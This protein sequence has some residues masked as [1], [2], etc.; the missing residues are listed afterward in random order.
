MKHLFVRIDFTASGAF[1][2]VM[3]NGI[4]QLHHSIADIK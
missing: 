4:F 1:A 3:A 2:G